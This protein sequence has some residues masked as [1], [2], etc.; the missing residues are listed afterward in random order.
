MR[1]HELVIEGPRGW[2]LGYMQGFVRGSGVRHMVFDAE[3]EGFDCEPFREH[4]RELL[5]PMAEILH[6]LAPAQLVPRL[7]RAVKESAAEGRKM[8][9]LHDRPVA[10]ARFNF[11]FS[12]YSRQHATRL[13]RALETLKG[14]A[15]L[16]KG[17][18]F[19]EIKDPDARGV[20]M[21]AP[22]HHYELHGKGGVEGD[23][24]G[25]LPIYRLCRNEELSRVKEAVLLPAGGKGKRGGGGKKQR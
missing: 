12:I 13:R 11:E 1:Y 21:Y 16:T 22:A 24:D 20:E 25:V 14:G 6:L 18:R 5:N 23:I 15:Q 19:D 3:E 10:G 17:T 9:I 2:G 8:N 7:R 4:V